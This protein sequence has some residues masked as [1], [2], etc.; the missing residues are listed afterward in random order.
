M[1]NNIV[2]IKQ[3]NKMQDD[4]FA[5]YVKKCKTNGVKPESQSRYFPRM[6]RKTGYMVLGR[7]PYFIKNKKDF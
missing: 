4:E 2:T 5:D 6:N 3:F 1:A 7:F